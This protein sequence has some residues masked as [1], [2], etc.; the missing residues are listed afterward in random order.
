MGLTFSDGEF[1]IYYKQ[2]S[3]GLVMVALYVDDLI[4][5]A[6]NP[7]ILASIKAGLKK[8]Y[9]MK[10]L[11]PISKF[12]G[13]NITQHKDFSVTLSLCDYISKAATS[14]SVIIAKSAPTPLSASVD[15]FDESSPLVTDITSYQSIIGQL[16]FISNAG[17][18][19]ISYSISLVSDS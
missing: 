13:M 2:S 11:G 19:D 3:S 1:G 14:S 5:A 7:Q 9:S 18:P 17:R 16:L 15:Y 10:D 6:P 4:I 8:A 12:L